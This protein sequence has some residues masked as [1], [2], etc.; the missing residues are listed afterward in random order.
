MP[1]PYGVPFVVSYISSR[2]RTPASSH[3]LSS[4]RIRGSAILCASIRSSHSWSIESKKLRISAS[5]TQFTRRL[6]IAVGIIRA[7]EYSL[8]SAPTLDERGSDS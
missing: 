3:I 1:A 2:S 6:M 7:N 5:S 8:F 4:R